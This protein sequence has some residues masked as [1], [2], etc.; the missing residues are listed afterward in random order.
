MSE[1]EA[2][3]DVVAQYPYKS[4]YEDDLSFEKDQV[5]TVTSIEDNEWYYGEYKNSTG[6]LMEGI[7]PKGFVVISKGSTSPSHTEQV[8]DTPVE[9]EEANEIEGD[10][11]GEHE[12]FVDAETS[13]S[14][15]L[16]DRVTIFNQ[17]QS[18]SAPKPRTSA[19]FDYERVPIKET[20]VA[21]PPQYYV[22]PPISS[23]G[24]HSE[25]SKKGPVPEPINRAE[26]ERGETTEYSK[27]DMPK[28]SLKERIALLQEQQRL[29]AEREEE[30]QKKKTKKEETMREEKI[31]ETTRGE[32][33]SNDKVDD[34]SQ[35]IYNGRKGSIH[36][37]HSEISLDPSKEAA[38]G[39]TR[40]TFE[41][42]DPSKPEPV[43]FEEQEIHE[44]Q[45]DN[46]G[47]VQEVEDLQS[48]MQNS[49]VEEADNEDEDE[50]Q[51]DDDD[52]KHDREEVHDEKEDDEEED[53]EETRRA[54]LRNRM[55][56]LAGAGRFGGAAGFNPFGMPA[57]GAPAP[58]SNKR[59]K[60]VKKQGTQE[61]DQ[62]P[63]TVPS[64]NEVSPSS[65][66]R[67][68]ERPTEIPLDEES[69]H[70][71]PPSN[72]PSSL[73]GEASEKIRNLPP[74]G[75]AEDNFKQE[76]V[77]DSNPLPTS[78]SGYDSS[79]EYTV[80]SSERFEEVSNS[81]IIH[82]PPLPSVVVPS[83]HI[84][85][86]SNAIDD[87]AEKEGI[88]PLNSLPAVPDL[89]IKDLEN[90]P[91]PPVPSAPAPGGTLGQKAPLSAVPPLPSD[92]P[93]KV[94]H[95][96][97]PPPPTV[98]PALDSTRRE[99][100]PPIPNVS[101]P[102]SR[103]APPPPI[104]N[105]SDYT[106]RAAPP[107]PVPPIPN[108]SDPLS[109][110]A[111]PP[112]IPQV[113]AHPSRDAPPPPPPAPSVPPPSDHSIGAAPVVPT[114]EAKTPSSTSKSQATVP[115]E[116]TMLMRRNTTKETMESLHET[117]VDFDPKD[118]WW[119]EKTIPTNLFSP[120]V[121]YLMEVDDKLIRKRL[122]QNFAVRDFYFLFEDYSQLH[123][124]LTFDVAHPEETVYAMQR[125]VPLKGE[126][127]LLNS[128]SEKYRSFIFQKAQ[129]LMHSQVTDLVGSIL[130][131]LEQDII[132]PIGSRTYGIPMVSYKA[133]QPVD[134]NSLKNVKAGDIL[135][136]RKAKFENH[137]KL[138]MKDTITV[139]ADSVPYAS[140]VT[141]FDF[142]KNKFRVIEGRD[143][144]VVQSS[145]KLAHMRSGKLKVFRV[146]GKSYVGW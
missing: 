143:G 142:I 95:P 9:M 17:D 78:T 3:F 139:G 8:I 45:E 133:G 104:P 103:A 48:R 26:V 14:P 36:P 40:E 65:P 97:P 72:R 90:S 131:R 51:N 44:I 55:A 86:T 5:I 59:S 62:L 74:S 116:Q 135:V 56:K 107:A 30:K 114:S 112:P 54:A 144:K 33:E 66:T 24:R 124:A 64:S 132:M 28:M 77:T 37:P 32:G 111:P 53:D 52:D 50:E 121:K 122:N 63:Q 123:L 35:E 84:S 109:R 11:T 10:K 146:V 81:P 119:L 138:G 71:H 41:D 25:E 1:P 12:H 118:L 68:F 67:N 7:F 102:L 145:Y 69:K 92:L 23:G 80:V 125:F 15:K 129:S 19:F 31:E 89:P 105:V 141:D 27:A 34:G 42:T 93:V 43:Q 47:N 58:S 88:L 49:E 46:N 96:P 110:A 83:P 91:P 39:G 130:A 120:K 140:V 126:S 82:I 76:A 117:S 29:Q 134:P 16:K 22:P 137:N 60:S 75:F 4:E 113:S 70:E 61:R 79:D 20:V 38:K 99:A 106:S 128:L 100:P 127:E 108:V 87:T 21:D 136:I 101:D 6:Q 18:E 2:P 98:A 85:S 94:T 115:G 73:G 57:G 13:G